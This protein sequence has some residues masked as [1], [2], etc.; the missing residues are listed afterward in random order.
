MDF[1]GVCERESYSL[2]DNFPPLRGSITPG[3][4]RYTFWIKR[5]QIVNS[6][7]ENRIVV[8][9]INEKISGGVNKLVKISKV[10]SNIGLEKYLPDWVGSAPQTQ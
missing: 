10:N 9:K 6:Q 7:V 8:K 5:L 4:P 2:G 1:P 3:L